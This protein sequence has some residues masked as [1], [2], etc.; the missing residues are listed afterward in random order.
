MQTLESYLS[1][2]IIH[3][4]D[5]I[6]A[7]E[8]VLAETGDAILAT[9]DAKFGGWPYEIPDRRSD[10][11]KV[12]QSTLT[13]MIRAIDLLRESRLA[14]AAR[15]AFAFDI[16]E[17]RGEKLDEIR[18]QAL[19]LLSSELAE[20]QKPRGAGVPEI[21]VSPTYGRNDPLTLSFLAEV[22]SSPMGDDIAGKKSDE[23]AARPTP[24][25]KEG[26]ENPASPEAAAP[27]PHLDAARLVSA[28]M[29]AIDPVKSFRKYFD[30]DGIADAIRTDALSNAFV[31]L[32]AVRAHA[33]LHDGEFDG[34]NAYLRYFESTLHDHLSYSHVPDSRFDPAEMIFALEGTLRLSEQTI[35]PRLFDRILDVL[36]Q[37]QQTSAH[38]RPSKPFLRTEKGLVLF[39]VSVEAANSLLW[40]CQH[41]DEKDEGFHSRSERCI[42]LFRRFWNWLQARRVPVTHAPSGLK[43]SGWHSDHVADHGSIQL[44]DTAQVVGFLLGYRRSLYNH[45]ARTTL[46]LSRFNVRKP[47]R[48]EHSW[49]PE[50][51]QRQQARG[52]GSSA[53]NDKANLREGFEPVTSLGPFFETYKKVEQDFLLPWLDGSPENYS[54]LLYGPPG[55]GKTSIVENLADALG[56]PMITITVSDF[57]AGGGGEVEARAKA[58]FDVLEAQANTVILFDEID[59]LVLDRN[60]DRH[61]KQDTVFKFMTPG[62]LTKLNDLRRKK[63]CIFAMATNFA[64][65]IDPAIRRTGRIDQNY[66][67]LPPDSAARQRMIRRFLGKAIKNERLEPQAPLAPVQISPEDWKRLE[68][69]SFFL[70]YKDIEAATQRIVRGNQPDI[71]KLEDAMLTAGRTTTLSAYN[72]IFKAPDDRSAIEREFYPLVEMARREGEALKRLKMPALDIEALE[73]DVKDGTIEAKAETF[74]ADQNKGYTD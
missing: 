54:M 48:P 11:R 24:E 46:R 37:A 34:Q 63:R 67:L 19:T 73:E 5:D 13:M 41:L 31:P 15:P 74:V 65:R 36:E 70:G 64:Y 42:A 38:W 61:E 47:S 23:E 28:A 3:D 57:L 44:W 69:A 62:M 20:S 14:G 25:A 17:A 72:K 9:F 66:L 35:D 22:L 56:F 12:S 18:P 39:P 40:S 43:L 30:T 45:I 27:L 68:E 71:K 21:T 16:G 29:T 4:R 32:M 55:T 53:S 52:V 59:E 26:P 2:N 51:S 33:R 8:R 49:S 7:I 10:R 50:S 60:S 1:E 58:I 6:A